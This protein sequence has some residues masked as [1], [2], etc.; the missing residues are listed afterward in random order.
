MYC[1]GIIPLT[2]VKGSEADQSPTVSLTECSRQSPRRDITEVVSDAN[3][4]P[5]SRGPDMPPLL[6]PLPSPGWPT[7]NAEELARRRSLS[8]LNRT[9]P[10]GSLAADLLDHPEN[11]RVIATKAP[12]QTQRL[13]SSVKDLTESLSEMNSC[14]SSPSSSEESEYGFTAV[15]NKNQENLEN[16]KSLQKQK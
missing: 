14:K 15:N 11:T 7:F 12:L 13:I 16:V 1:N 10:R 9:P 4:L 8:L 5:L 2:P 3:V 6:S